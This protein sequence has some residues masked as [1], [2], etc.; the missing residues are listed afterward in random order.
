MPTLVCDSR[1]VGRTL[2]AGLRQASLAVERLDKVFVVRP[3]GEHDLASASD[4][5]DTLHALIN[6]DFGIVVDV[7][8]VDFIDIAIVR[9]LLDAN[10]ALGKRQRRLVLQFGTACPVCKVFHLTGTEKLFACAEDRAAAVELAR[11]CFSNES[12]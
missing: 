11:A 7:S 10:R 12:P 9:V 6:D 8:A 3:L 4:L 5:G 1:G 2:M